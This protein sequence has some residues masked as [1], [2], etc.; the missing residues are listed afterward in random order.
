MKD[1]VRRGRAG[2]AR[3]RRR[4]VSASKGQTP[5]RPG[6]YGPKDHSA[7][8]WP[9][10]PRYRRDDAWA[11]ELPL[12]PDLLP[13]CVLVVAEGLD[14][15]CLEHWG[16][17]W[18]D[19]L[20]VYP[21]GVLCTPMRMVALWWVDL[22]HCR[23]VLPSLPDPI[24]VAAQASNHSTAPIL[25]A[26]T[27]PLHPNHLLHRTGN[28]PEGRRTM[29]PGRGS[30]VHSIRQVARGWH[31]VLCSECIWGCQVVEGWPPFAVW[32][33]RLGVW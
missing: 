27:T 5:A 10:D 13:H 33:R 16:H 7:W 28:Q 3:A 30:Q 15:E 31:R 12:H 29:Q 25:G 22:H 11:N 9:K 20:E 1:R 23:D 24:Q 26:L 2:G 6:I 8:G 18:Q 14:V 17:E 19:L 4:Q 21:V 32:W